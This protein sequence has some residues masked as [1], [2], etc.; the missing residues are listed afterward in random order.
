[1]THFRIHH[2]LYMVLEVLSV[3]LALL[4]SVFA[5]KIIINTGLTTSSNLGHN[6]FNQGTQSIVGEGLLGHAETILDVLHVHLHIF[7]FYFPL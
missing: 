5:N 7:H 6:T 4:D 1:M 3:A 2:L